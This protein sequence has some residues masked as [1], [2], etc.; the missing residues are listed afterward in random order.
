M[1]KCTCA[2]PTSW[3]GTSPVLINTPSRCFRHASHLL[4]VNVCAKPRL[5]QIQLNRRDHLIRLLG[6]TPSTLHDIR[7]TTWAPK[8]HPQV[9]TGN[10]LMPEPTDRRWGKP[11]KT[12]PNKEGPGLGRGERAWWSTLILLMTNYIYLFTTPSFVLCNMATL[13]VLWARLLIGHTLS[14]TIISTPGCT[15]RA[16]SYDGIA[17]SSWGFYSASALA[18]PVSSKPCVAFGTTMIH[19][20]RC[21]RAVLSTEGSSTRPHQITDDRETLLLRILFCFPAICRNNS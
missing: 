3:E 10:M 11:Y 9:R 8:I 20:N 14:K 2:G 19:L 13:S 17:A 6:V 18:S 21:T 7:S 1:V 16:S 4:P 5:Q 15:S 12:S